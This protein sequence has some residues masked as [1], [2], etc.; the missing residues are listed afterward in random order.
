MARSY[1]NEEDVQY[2]A[3][4]FISHHLPPLRTIVMMYSAR[5]L[6][7][8]AS[9]ITDVGFPQQGEGAVV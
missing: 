3:L 4:T 9:L 1:L 7:N 8:L 6:G 5:S 2:K